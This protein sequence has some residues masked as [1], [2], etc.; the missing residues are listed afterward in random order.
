MISGDYDFLDKVDCFFNL[1]QMS[2]NKD[3]NIKRNT[4]LKSLNIE[5]KT[6]IKDII[7]SKIIF[8]KLNKNKLLEHFRYI[9][10]YIKT[11]KR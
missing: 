7:I 11:I 9:W 6:I 5:Y 1:F 10:Y 3:K 4:S 8:I 2:D